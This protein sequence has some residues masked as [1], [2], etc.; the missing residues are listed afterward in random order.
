MSGI[1][2]PFED[3]WTPDDLKDAINASIGHGK[4]REFLE[5]LQRKTAD[6]SLED[7]DVS[8]ENGPWYQIFLT[9]RSLW[10][11]YY[12]V[13]N[14]REEVVMTDQNEVIDALEA[15]KD[16]LPDDVDPRLKEQIENAIVLLC[17][18]QQELEQDTADDD[19]DEY[20]A[21]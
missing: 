5:D 17:H 12:S 1:D 2:D 21:A 16:T 11:E 20:I 13:C 9:S 6:F 14:G 7:H 15:A 8:V 3:A 19:G 10:T 18:L 4:W